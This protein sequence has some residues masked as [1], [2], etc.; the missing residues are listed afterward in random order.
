MYETHHTHNT[1]RKV[2]PLFDTPP[3]MISACHELRARGARQQGCDV[4]TARPYHSQFDEFR[5]SPMSSSAGQK[6]WR[7]KSLK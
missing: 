7:A 6:K 5:A 3:R 2:Y 1:Q 4:L